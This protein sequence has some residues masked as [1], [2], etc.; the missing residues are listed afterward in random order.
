METVLLNDLQRQSKRKVPRAALQRQLRAYLLES[1]REP[2]VRS[3]C[4]HTEATDPCSARSLKRPLV[5]GRTPAL[6]ADSARASSF[7]MSISLYT[8]GRHPWWD[9]CTHGSIT[10]CSVHVDL[11]LVNREL[12]QG[13][14]SKCHGSA[15]S[16]L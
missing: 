3:A 12:L 6:S 15:D 1:E 2:V 4:T 14:L 8:S 11:N 9:I 7:S 5:R 10:A 16:P 13:C